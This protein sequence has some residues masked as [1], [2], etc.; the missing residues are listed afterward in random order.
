VKKR[1]ERGLGRGLSAL[2]PTVTEERITIEEIGLDL[3]SSRKNQPRKHFD[4]AQL[5]ELAVS[6]R[7]H[8]VLQ[9]VLLNEIDGKY[10]IIA[11]ERR[12]RAARMAELETLPA[13]T[14]QL[15]SSQVAEVALIE[16]LQREDLSVLEEASAYSQLI[17]LHGYTQEQLAENIGKSRAHITNTLRLLN[18]PEKIKNML[19]DKL[20]TPGHARALLTLPDE[21]QQI[22][23]AEN[24]QKKGLSVRAVEK[25]VREALAV[26]LPS[27]PKSP[28]PDAERQ[29]WEEKLQ[30]FFGCKV[31]LV[32]NDQGKLE[33]FYYDQE[34]L[35]R[36]LNLIGIDE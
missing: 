25:L 32:G 11:G 15:T 5:E 12:W 8:G 20:I 16:N 18:L 23:W 2:L 9:P 19:A 26:S 35:A 28:P 17:S 3:I 27:A 6:I 1:I 34:E 14:M 24:I 21:T 31:R 4:Q 30:S 29:A 7:Q 33:I 22:A 36:V 10:E 13:I